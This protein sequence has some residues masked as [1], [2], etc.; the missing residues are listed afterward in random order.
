MITW[1]DEELGIGQEACQAGDF[2]REMT[3]ECKSTD[4][5][6]KYLVP[7]IRLIRA[8]QCELAVMSQPFPRYSNELR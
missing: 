8:E 5:S 3:I 7:L 4:D 6:V 1:T 2:Q